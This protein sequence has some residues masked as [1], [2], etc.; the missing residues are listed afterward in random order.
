[1]KTAPVPKPIANLSGVIVGIGVGG[2]PVPSWKISK[3]IVRVAAPFAMLAS[4][5]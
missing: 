4:P 2:S 1:M 3:V 5:N